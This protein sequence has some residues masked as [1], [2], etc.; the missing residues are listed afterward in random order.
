[1]GGFDRCPQC[2]GQADFHAVTTRR[3]KEG[4]EWLRWVQCQNCGLFVVAD[5]FGTIV[6]TSREAPKGVARGS[7][8]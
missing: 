7:D 3:T 5:E 4:M 1:V 8:S 6:K 2:R